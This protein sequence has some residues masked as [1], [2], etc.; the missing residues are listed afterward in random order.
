MSSRFR[1]LTWDTCHLVVSMPVGFVSMPFRGE[2]ISEGEKEPGHVKQVRPAK[3]N[4][5]AQPTNKQCVQ[6]NTCVGA[7]RR[8]A[9]VNLQHVPSDAGL[10]EDGRLSLSPSIPYVFRNC[11]FRF[12]DAVVS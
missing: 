3:K 7:R 11:Q 1:L 8:F 4:A 9:E 12:P 10:L 6:G 5:G 2:G